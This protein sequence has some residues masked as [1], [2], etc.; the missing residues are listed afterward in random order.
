MK[1]MYNVLF[2][3]KNNE[4]IFKAVVCCSRD[5]RLQ[6]ILRKTRGYLL[7]VCLEFSCDIAVSGLR[8][9]SDHIAIWCVARSCM[10]IFAKK[11]LT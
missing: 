9:R 5:W 6:G 1:C 8:H 2:S 10:I 4:N 11:R 7:Q 3:L